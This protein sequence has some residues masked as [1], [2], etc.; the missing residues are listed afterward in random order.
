MPEPVREICAA[1]AKPLRPVRLGPND[2]VMERLPD[3]TLRLRSPHP[4]PPYPNKLTEPLE[5][6]A[7]K[8]PDRVFLA[9]RDAQGGWRTLSYGAALAQ[10]RVIAG[11]LL[12]RDL[13]PERPIAVLSGNDIEQALLGLAAAYVG[14]PYAPISPAY[15]LMSSDFGKLRHIIGLLTPGLVFAA[16][17]QPFA[18][19]IEAVMP[20]G[21]ELVVTRN[22]LPN[23]PTTPFQSLLDFTATAAV[24]AAHG[25]VGP[26]TIVKFLFTSGS[27]GQPKGV[28]NTQRMLCSNQA[29]VSGG[30]AYVQDEPPIIVDWLPWSHTFGSNH[31]FGLVLFNGGSL[32]I[33]EGK[34]L[35]G[36]INATV[37]NLREVATTIYFNVPKG[38]EM[39]LPHLRADR[40]LRERFF[41][42]L[43]V[44]FYAGAGL[45]QHV[46]DELQQ[47]AVETTGERIIFLSS[48]GSTET[49]PLALALTR[50]FRSLRQ[51]RR[52]GAGRG[53]QA[54][55]QRRQARGAARRPQHH[56]RLL[57][58]AAAHRRRVRCR[59]L[60]QD[61]RRAQIR[62]SSGPREGPPVRR[63]D[64]GGLQARDRHLG[65]RRPAARAIHRSLRALCARRGDCRRPTAMTSRC[66]SSPIST[67][68]AG[69]ARTCRPT[70]H[71]TS[72]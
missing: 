71:P 61:R 53:A 51:H 40:E 65:Q 60:L 29:M 19:A 13:S 72:C 41:S 58:A 69:F 55:A 17:S 26:D 30:F 67:P 59:G 45:A 27:T 1:T 10:V 47:L 38:Y 35:P 39:L 21:T 49:A 44:M 2:C 36:A 68:A 48:I 63:T 3:G 43:R 5:H 62:R 16:D 20:A 6:W 22:P 54:R 34:P 24:D 28:I 25:R 12:Q 56:A 7:A 57:A 4:L 32:Y 8:A 46:W 66:W 50:E 15:S 42:R 9:Q 18:R 14:I 37:R 52:A 31:N 64:R 23:R 70:P 33:D 11:A